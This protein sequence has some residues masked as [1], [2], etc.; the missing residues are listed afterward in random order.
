M[1]PK[2]IGLMVGSTRRP[3]LPSRD[4]P[5]KSSTPRS[6]KSPSPGPEL[7]L[8]L[9][10][11]VAGVAVSA[12]ISRATQ[13]PGS[14]SGSFSEPPRDWGS[15]EAAVNSEKIVLDLARR[16]C[17]PEPSGPKTEASQWLFYRT[18]P[19]AGATGSAGPRDPPVPCVAAAAA[20]HVA[21]PP[22]CACLMYA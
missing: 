11:Q 15:T 18:D 22:D 20:L 4:T 8:S 16:G 7:P 17:S 19:L 6:Q 9:L 21:C 10:L 13:R 3:R 1:P 5:H 2:R 12:T 14:P